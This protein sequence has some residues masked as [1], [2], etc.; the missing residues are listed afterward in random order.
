MRRGA[1]A[2]LTRE[3]PGLRGIVVGARFVAGAEQSLLDHLVLAAVLCDQESRALSDEHVVFFNQLT[4]PDLSVNRLE[5][6]LGGDTEQVE[7]DLA[8]VPADVARIVLVAYLNDG[9][10]GRRTLGQLRECT[11]RV[12]DLATEAELVR[13]E[14]LA[15]ALTEETAL[16]LGEIYRHATEWK[17]KVL[18]LGYAD[19]IVGIARDYGVPL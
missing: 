7:V 11:V 14:N 3:I 19:G 1:N 4:S 2:A 12:L 16:V 9:I 10:G 15:P 6:V 8:A 13:S 5:Q 18:G 17:F